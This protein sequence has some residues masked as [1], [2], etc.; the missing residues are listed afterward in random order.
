MRPFR[1]LEYPLDQ[2]VTGPH[3]V[4]DENGS[5]LVYRCELC[6]TESADP[7]LQRGCYKCDREVGWR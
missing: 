4:S 6:G 3:V 5:R 7:A 1:P 2:C